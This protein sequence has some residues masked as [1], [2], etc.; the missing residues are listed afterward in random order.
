MDKLAH[1]KHHIG[2]ATEKVI[3]CFYMMIIL[4]LFLMVLRFMSKFSGWKRYFLEGA[5]ESVSD[6][7]VTYWAVLRLCHCLDTAQWTAAAKKI[8]LRCFFLR[9]RDLLDSDGDSLTDNF[10]PIQVFCKKTNKKSHISLFKDFN[11]TF[12]KFFIFLNSTILIFLI[13]WN[14]YF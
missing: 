1:G 12:E 3:L 14:C 5:T 4:I 8:F 9:F 10:R 11:F 7:R 2:E 6:K 13:T